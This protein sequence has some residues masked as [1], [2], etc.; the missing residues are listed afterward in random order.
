MNDLIVIIENQD[1][2]LISIQNFHTENYALIL[3]YHHISYCLEKTSNLSNFYSLSVKNL[4]KGSLEFG[5]ILI[6][7]DHV[8]SEFLLSLSHFFNFF[9][10]FLSL[11]DKFIQIWVALLLAEFELDF[12]LGLIYI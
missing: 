7:D 4:S 9:L 2:K 3:E 10:L 6:R 12:S 5:V 11:F 1:L 8:F